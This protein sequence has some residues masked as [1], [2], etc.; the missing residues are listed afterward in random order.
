MEAASNEGIYEVYRVPKSQR[1]EAEQEGP[2][3]EKGA[4]GGALQ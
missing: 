4:W 1:K 2:K 3:A